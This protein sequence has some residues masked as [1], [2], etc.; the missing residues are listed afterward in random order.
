MKRWLYLFLVVFLVSGCV[1]ETRVNGQEVNNKDKQLNKDAAAKTRISLALRYLEAGDA[2]QAKRNLELAQEL[3]PNLVDVYIAQA[4]F[5]QSV[6]Q[7][8][9]ALDAYKRAKSIAPRNGDVLNNYGVML[10]KQKEYDQAEELFKQALANPEYVQ[11]A[12]TNENAG[13][14]AL[15]AGDLDK[16]LDYFTSALAY[17]IRRPASLLGAT[18][19]YLQK[20]KPEQARLYLQRYDSMAETTAESAF[21]WV[22]LESAADNFAEEARWGLTLQQ[23]FPKSEQTKRYI[24]ND[25]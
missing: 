7:P 18:E 10:C 11:V 25:Y 15:T 1:T 16:A 14:C 6:R 17:N 12:G 5:Y 13:L 2:E 8:E 20:N 22:R 19:V 4:H 23:Q 3:A 21:A 24:A 9:R